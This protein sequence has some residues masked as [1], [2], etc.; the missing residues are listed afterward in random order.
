MQ[1][2]LTTILP[3]FAIIVLG[4]CLRQFN[5]IQEGFLVQANRLVYFVAIPAMIF[6]EVSGITLSL[7]FD[8][9]TVAA[10]LLPL[11]IVIAAGFF[12]LRLVG[13][14][15]S[16]V[17]TFLQCSFHGNLGYVGLAVS[18][19]FLG[20]DGFTRASIFAGFLILLQ[21]VLSV[22]LLHTFSSAARASRSPAVVVRQ[23][24]FNPIILAVT[25]GIVSSSL[26]VTLPVLLNRSLQILS[27][28]ALPLALLLIGASISFGKI[29]TY[30]R[31]LLSISLS[32]LVLLPAV[33]LLLFRMLG[34]P[35][36]NLLPALIL[37]A[38]PTATVSYVMAKAIGGDASLATAA[39][40]LTTLVS[41]L[42]FMFWLGIPS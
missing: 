15:R 19:Y 31:P 37:L 8:P 36:H 9:F 35:K 41:A 1:Q 30:L 38:S 39:V 42:T 18:Y 27:G 17:G 40:S 5:F 20:K 33:G 22:T 25:A 2:M 4:C 7:Y 24:L 23:I 12:Q 6:H 14:Q 16:Q 29:R 21:N 3:I 11:P 13:L 10:M 32:K 34:I 28:M 26:A